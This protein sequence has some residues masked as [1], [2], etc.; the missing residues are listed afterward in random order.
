MGTGE[1]R[2]E[3]NQ[4][5]ED[6][7][8]AGSSLCPTLSD[9]LG[10]AEAGAGPQ[11]GD[12]VPAARGNTLPITNFLKVEPVGRSPLPPPAPPP[13]PTCFLGVLGM[14]GTQTSPLFSPT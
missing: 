9:R 5:W 1:L 4:E 14:G 11:A 7:L 13:Q 8:R 12:L 10:S 3:R 6:A 2:Q